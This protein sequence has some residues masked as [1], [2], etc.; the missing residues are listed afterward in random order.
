VRRCSRLLCL[1][2]LSGPAST[3]TAASAAAVT[4]P[5]GSGITGLVFIG[6]VCP[7]ETIQPAPECGDRPYV[8]TLEFRRSATGTLVRTARSNRQ[9]RFTARLAPGTYLLV[10][11]PGRGIARPLRPRRAIR[12]V[13]N[14]FTSV[15]VEYDSG[16]RFVGG[17]LR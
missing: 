16:I 15:R 14:R 12:V 3:P 6:P 10:P 4:P 1:L 17:G 8:A 5:A 13:A 7:V 9:G 2:A 11:R